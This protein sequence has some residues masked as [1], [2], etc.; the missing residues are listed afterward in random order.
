MSGPDNVNYKPKCTK[1]SQI[2]RKI[3]SHFSK[4]CLKTRYLCQEDFTK[5]TYRIRKPGRYIVT[6]DIIFNPN[7]ENDFRPD[8]TDDKYKSDAYVLGF[9]AAITVESKDVEIDLNGKTIRQSQAFYLQ[10]R[11]FSVIELASAP[12]VNGQGPADF[13]KDY[14]YADN[15][16]IHDGELAL[17]SHHGIHGNGARNVLIEK[18]RCF[19]F[20]VC[21]IA[22]NGGKYICV[23]HVEIGNNQQDVPVLGIYS[24]FRFLIQFYR[25]TIARLEDIGAD[26]FDID[27]L[28]GILAGMEAVNQTVL[29]E[30]LDTGKV[31]FQPFHNPTGLPDGNVFGVL[32]HPLGVAVNDFVEE[33]FSGYLAKYI[34]LSHVN[35]HGIAGKPVEVIGISADKEG[36]GVQVDPSGSIFQIVIA[37]DVVGNYVG[38]EV[39]G[40]QLLLAKMAI[41]YDLQVGKMNI[42]QDTIDWSESGQSYSILLDAGYMMKCNADSMNHVMKGVVAVRLDG[43]AHTFVKNV[44]I[45]YIRNAGFLGT[46]SFCGH[47]VFSNDNQI[48]KGYHGGDVFGVTLCCSD[49][50]Y[51]KGI[52]IKNVTTRNGSAYGMRLMNHSR[53][54]SVDDLFLKTLTSFYKFEDGVYY[55]QRYDGLDTDL[56]VSYPN[57]CPSAFGICVEDSNC[58]YVNIGDFKECDI[59]APCTTAKLI[60]KSDETPTGD[61]GKGHG[62]SDTY[63]KDDGKDD[64]SS[65]AYE[66]SDSSDDDGLIPCF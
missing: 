49:H 39:T 56:L 42:T 6:E 33:D 57:H 44:Q 51:F 19:N 52:L 36:K 48:R 40:A 54:I 26:Q 50:V 43:V 24:A 13:G 23:K 45:R 53:Q 25:S 20:E 32:F 46:E 41:K 28:K 34:S 62:K 30:Y 14:R 7:P 8:P 61:S 4:L 64:K 58:D 9:F 3:K 17:S 5:G 47:Y 31:T 55:F 27:E 11:F 12:F 21:G 22:V 1:G 10:Q 18:V 15:C 63:N 60:Y 66:S 2:C 38:N 16:W 65:P 35:I 29:D 37:S 59:T